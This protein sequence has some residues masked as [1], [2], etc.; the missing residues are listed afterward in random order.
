MELHVLQ[1]KQG[2][3]PVLLDA[4][5]RIIGPVYDF[6]RFQRLK[7]RAPNTLIANGRDLKVYWEFLQ[8]TGL[9]YEKISPAELAEFIGYLRYGGE[10]GGMCQSEPGRTGQT[11]NRIL[12]TVHMF[13]QY[14]AD[15]QEINNPVLMRD[16]DRPA[17]MFKGLLYHARKDSRTKQSIFKV[18]ENSY[19]VHLVTE[20]EMHLFLSCL[21]KKR[22]ILLYKLLYFTG[23]RIQEILD[24]EIESVPVPDPTIGVG[25]FR[26]IRSKGKARDLYVPMS[27]IE[28]LDDFI[29]GERSRTETEH[30]YVFI[31]EHPGHKG[32]QLTYRAAYD[33]LK[34]VQE[35]TGLSF[36]FHDLRHSFCSRLAQT[37]MDASI[38]RIIMGHEHIA[39]TQRYTHLSENYIGTAL[40]RYWEGSIFGGVGNEQ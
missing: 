28:E 5:I 22:D 37:G 15:M 12:S 19:R 30:S 6:L 14:H 9:S 40:S 34:K 24:L 4:E 16:Q 10:D 3:M 31:S 23:A 36:N 21:D 25:V 32:K 29:F 26:Q 39:T 20:D 38:I 2:V 18:K 27:L 33:K 1:M 35:Q 8:E 11:V 13:Y 7:G 17:N